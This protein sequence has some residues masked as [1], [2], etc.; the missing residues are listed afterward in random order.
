[1]TLGV[2]LPNW[3]GDVLLARRALD[4]L[5]AAD[6]APHV[7][8][9]APIVALLD[10]DYPQA[11]WIP[12]GH[13][14]SAALSLGAAWRRAGIERAV[15][16]P[17]SLSSRIAAWHSG[18]RARVGFDRRPGGVRE[19]AAAWGLTRVVPR[20]ERGSRHLEDEYLDLA[21]AAGGAPRERRPLVLPAAAGERAAALLGPLGG[22]RYVAVAPGA[23]YGPAKRWPAERFAEAARGLADRYGGARVVVIGEA[24]DAA[25][26][27]EVSRR[28]GAAALDLAGRTDLL[29]VAGVIAGCA[30]FLGND[31]GAAHLAAALGR[32]AIAVFGSTDPR[33]TAPR[34]AGAHPLWYRLRC[35][36]CFRA[37]CP[38]TEAY[39]CLRV[40][41]PR[42]VLA[43]NRRG[44]G[45]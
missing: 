11:R 34:G 10:A 31:S 44:A 7:A 35:A 41:E 38:W 24:D 1:V 30:V 37:T 25:A 14:F 36:P 33:W 45:A 23:R 28:L 18:A 40:I 26:C 39:A 12:T 6:P 5:V 4:A 27:A 13:G 21:A 20:C 22:A 9:P 17:V 8:A 2:R 16:F 3:L 32:P 43:A 19:P 42:D 29:T 15:V